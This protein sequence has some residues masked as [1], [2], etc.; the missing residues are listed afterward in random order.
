M[1]VKQTEIARKRAGERAT[2]HSNT[3]RTYMLMD[4]CVYV[5]IH[6]LNV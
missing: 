5:C 4:V 2:A 3:A 6:A 1:F